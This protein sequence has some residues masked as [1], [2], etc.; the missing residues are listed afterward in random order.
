MELLKGR[1]LLSALAEAGRL[2]WQDVFRIMSVVCDALA[3]A[4]VRG[5][6]HRD[7]KPDNIFLTDGGPKV[8]DFG[9]AKMA[10][11]RTTRTGTMMGTPHYMSPEQIT[12]SKDVDARADIYSCGVVL[13]HTIT[14]ALMYPNR[15]GNEVLV[16]ILN[17]PS[18]RLRSVASFVPEHV[19]LVVDRCTAKEATQ[20]YQSALELKMALEASLNAGGGAVRASATQPTL[21][22]PSESPTPYHRPLPKA[23][24]QTAPSPTTPQHT[25]SGDQASRPS[26]AP[27]P[28]PMVRRQPTT[29]RT[30]RPANIGVKLAGVGL[31][32][33]LSVAATVYVARHGAPS[34]SPGPT[35]APAQTETTQAEP[36]TKPAPPPTLGHVRV[37]SD[38]PGANVFVDG[39]PRGPAPVDVA[40]K[41]DQA[42]RVHLVLEGYADREDQVVPTVEGGEAFFVMKPAPASMGGKHRKH[43]SAPPPAAPAASATT[44]QQQPT[45]APQ[46]APKQ[47]Q[48]P[49]SGDGIFSDFED[50]KK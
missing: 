7:I 26:V 9:I 39:Q 40:G 43:A 14:G 31:A 6:V 28:V 24:L 10:Q 41:S 16:A 32:A 4:H 49:T 5:I 38:P 47:H 30:A 27:A 34:A 15:S 25:R 35:P 50:E 20:R 48:S 1:T 22:P 46:P 29:R 13:F 44:P 17:D 18:P 2:A 37:I 3:A 11:A 42:K 19:G 23:P 12:N 33:A 45:T 8:V 36:P 21:I